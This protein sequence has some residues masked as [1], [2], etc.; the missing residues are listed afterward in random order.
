MVKIIVTK[1]FVTTSI[2]YQG[3]QNYVLIGNVLSV[4]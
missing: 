3:N 4:F 1:L 2:T